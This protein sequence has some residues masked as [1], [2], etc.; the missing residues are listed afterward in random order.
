M[1]RKNKALSSGLVVFAIGGLTLLVERLTNWGVSRMIGKLYCG[2]HYLQAAGQ[3]GDGAC[4]FNMDMVVGMVSFLLCV[5]GIILVVIGLIKSI[6][7]RK[8]K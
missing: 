1:N 3:M 8:A 6:T 4:G 7:N 2:E 5:I